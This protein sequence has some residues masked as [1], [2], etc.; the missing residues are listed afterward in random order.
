[1]I[2]LAELTG[3]VEILGKAI[4]MGLGMIGPAIGI[5][6]VGNAFINAV[7]RNPEAAK[8]LGQALV[9]IGIIELMALLV[10]A[11]LFII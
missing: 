11:T 5:G 9:I 7:G 1:M 10:F 6:L 3:D 8:F 2:Y 4:M